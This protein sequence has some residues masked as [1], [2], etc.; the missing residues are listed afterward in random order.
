MDTNYHRDDVPS[1]CWCHDPICFLVM[2][3]DILINDPLPCLIAFLQQLESF[4][5]HGQ[6]DHSAIRVFDNSLGHKEC[7]DVA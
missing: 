7:M 6:R 5:G 4:P 2:L 1:P 3:H